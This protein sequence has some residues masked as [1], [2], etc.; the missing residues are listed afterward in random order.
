LFPSEQEISRPKKHDG[1]DRTG[2]HTSRAKIAGELSSH[3]DTEL[4]YFEVRMSSC[5]MLVSLLCGGDVLSL[6]IL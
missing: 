5:I 3:I 1:K 2:F 4:Q 6:S